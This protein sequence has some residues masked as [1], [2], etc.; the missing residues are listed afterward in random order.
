MQELWAAYLSARRSFLKSFRSDTFKEEKP[1][2]LYSCVCLGIC[3][4]G[5]ALG[6]KKHLFTRFPKIA[7]TPSPGPLLPHPYKSSSFPLSSF[8]CTSFTH[9]CCPSSQRCSDFFEC[10]DFKKSFLSLP[11]NQQL[12]LYFSQ[13]LCGVG[14]WEAALNRAWTVS[15]SAHRSDLSI[16]VLRFSAVRGWCAQ[17]IQGFVDLYITMAGRYLHTHAHPNSFL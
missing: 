6:I 13:H 4:T 12:L 14:G 9:T 16:A 8:F 17:L 2:I 3:K 15:I 11:C 7:S 10:T 5:A 1:D